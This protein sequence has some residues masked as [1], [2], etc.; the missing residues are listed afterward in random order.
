MKAAEFITEA[1]D[2]PYNLRWEKGDHG[3]DHDAIVLL[4]DGRYLSIM[5]NEEDEDE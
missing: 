5:F 2:Q 1:F 3:N 4:P